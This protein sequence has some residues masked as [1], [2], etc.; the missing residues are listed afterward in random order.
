MTLGETIRQL[1]ESRGWSQEELAG[2]SQ[3]S[4]TA[5]YTCEAD[6]TLPSLTVLVKICRA[7]GVS[8]GPLDD[9]TFKEDRRN[10]RGPRLRRRA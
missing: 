5:V 10:R 8:L 9:V 3:I 4:Y 2:K 6:S 1:R 7:L